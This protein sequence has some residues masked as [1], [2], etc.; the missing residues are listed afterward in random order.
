MPWKKSELEKWLQELVDAGNLSEPARKALL[1]QVAP[2]LSANEKA[3]SYLESS[4]LRQSR[5]NQKMDEVT[6]KEKTYNEAIEQSKQLQQLYDD[7][8]KRPDTSS[9]RL[10][11]LE[12]ELADV[13]AKAAQVYNELSVY[14]DGEAA[15]KKVG[16]TDPNAIFGSSTR[17]RQDLRDPAPAKAPSSVFDEEEFLKKLDSR[18]SERFNPIFQQLAEFAVD[19]QEMRDRYHALTGKTLSPSELKKT[20]GSKMAEMKTD[21]YWDAFN[22]AYNIPKLEREQEFSTRLESERKKWQEEHQSNLDRELLRRDGS[23]SM[24]GNGEFF[25]LLRDGS[26]VPEVQANKDSSLTPDPT[27]FSTSDEYAAAASALREVR[28]QA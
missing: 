23:S 8:R 10:T 26:D 28:G 27:T 18:Y 12:Q 4:Q 6:A 5:F 15:F 1:E 11:Q 19:S 9:A 21:N 24:E 14:E 13:R 20:L 16:W 7:L 17:G 3:L 2:E 25:K 22:A